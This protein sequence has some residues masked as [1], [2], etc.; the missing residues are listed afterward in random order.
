MKKI[1]TILC[2]VAACSPT[3]KE[4]PA[5]AAQSF[6]DAYTET[7]MDLL[8]KSNK[9]EWASNTQIIEGD[10]INGY[11]TRMANEAYSAFSGSKENIEKA[12]RLL[13]SKDELTDLQVR[14]L[15]AILYSA[16]NSPQTVEDLVKERISAET[17]Q[18][19]LLYGFDFQYKGESVSTNYLD[20]VLKTSDD[21][22]ERL[23]AW[24]ASK[25]VGV[26]LKDG[27]A[28]LQ[29]LRNKTVQA[30]NYNDYY[31]YQVSEYGMTVQEMTDLCDQLISDVWPLYRELHTYM[32]YTLA[33]KYGIDVPDLLPAHWLPNRWGQD[34]SAT[35][36]VE[37]VD[38]D[39]ILEEK[40]SEWLV[41]QSERFYVS[42]GF[43]A[44]PQSFYELSSLYPLPD[45][46]DYKKN[47]HASAWHLDRKLDVRSLMSVQPNAD[48]YETTHHELGHIYYYLEYTNPDVPPLLRRGANR[49]FH[50]AVGS[51]MGLA[52]MQKPF[53]AGLGLIDENQETD[54]IQ[55][56]L[57][58]AMNYIVFIPWSAGV[59]TQF[60]KLLYVDNLPK[61]QYNQKWWEL[62]NKYQGIVWPEERSEEYCDAASKTHI[63]NDAA[64]YYD[65]ALSFAILFQLHQHVAVNIL[66]EDPRS[67]NYYGSKEA[68]VFLQNIL[69]KGNTVDWRDL[70]KEATGEEINAKAMLNYFEPLMEYLKAQNEGRTHALPEVI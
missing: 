54:E 57:K 32:R 15:E 41:R 60:E 63:N 9:A 31:T 5:D 68:G 23:V 35:V 47:N 16:A 38:L 33:D 17:K 50:E 58:E 69:S 3:P 44:L 25:A 4:T 56:L 34:W 27:L 22:D 45:S 36:E 66:N 61:D 62:K 29:G 67:T 52:S 2:L 51:Q 21:L 26:G 24:N 64:Q 42:M 59:M 43:D 30:L 12:T 13:E 46:V 39:G 19:E 48:W 11:N 14:Q 70:M 28:N 65:Y 37:G 6:I 49:A 55:T 53:L 18:T 1:L 20:A 7:Y 10:T 40:G 8:Y